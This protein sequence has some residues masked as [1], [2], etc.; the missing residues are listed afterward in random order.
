MTVKST[1][2]GF[3]PHS[4]YIFTFICSFLRSGVKAKRGVE[5]RH[6]YAMLPEL[7]GKWGPCCERDTACLFLFY[8]KYPLISRT[9]CTTYLATYYYQVF[10]V[11][12]CFYIIYNFYYNFFI[13]FFLVF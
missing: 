7:G 6:A 12:L 3:D 10:E 8:I 9:A 5:F 1:G 13:I 4:K 11:G 2:C